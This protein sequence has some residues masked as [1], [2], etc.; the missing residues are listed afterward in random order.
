[1]GHFWDPDAVK[2]DGMSGWDREELSKKHYAWVN[3][4][5][6]CVENC[7]KWEPAF[8]KG[9]NFCKH[10]DD[11]DDA[12]FRCICHKPYDQYQHEYPEQ[13]DY[14][15][16]LRLFAANCPEKEDCKHYSPNREEGGICNNL[17]PYRPDVDDYAL[18]CRAYKKEEK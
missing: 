5:C 18:H 16:R 14:T 12:P 11:S 15:R 2:R 6:E 3:A 8:K 9:L 10:K 1:M 17:K 4:P 13:A 7:I